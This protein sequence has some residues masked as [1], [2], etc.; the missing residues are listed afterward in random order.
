MDYLENMIK[1]LE[2]N[3][4]DM[5]KGDYL[6][7]D[8]CLMKPSYKLDDNRVI[9]IGFWDF[10]AP[11]RNIPSQNKIFIP[12]V[13]IISDLFNGAD[14]YVDCLGD[15]RKEFG[16]QMGNYFSHVVIHHNYMKG[17]TELRN[18]FSDKLEVKYNGMNMESFDAKKLENKS[19]IELGSIVFGY[20]K[21]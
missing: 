12:D 8:H 15:F 1:K 9:T 20:F 4:A 21:K 3:F 17:H 13:D 6:V 18:C 7:F 11:F 5:Q 19:I 14:K 10:N 2:A 16:Y